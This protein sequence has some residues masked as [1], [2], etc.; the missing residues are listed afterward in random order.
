MLLDFQT[1]LLQYCPDFNIYGKLTGLFFS[2]SELCA[3]LCKL[4][5]FLIYVVVSI[6]HFL[7]SEW[8]LI[9]L[10]GPCFSSSS[11]IRLSLVLTSLILFQEGQ[12]RLES[13]GEEGWMK[14]VQHRY[15]SLLRLCTILIHNDRGQ[16]KNC[17][18]SFNIASVNFIFSFPYSSSHSSALQ[19]FLVRLR[20]F[21]PTK[22]SRLLFIVCMWPT[23]LSFQLFHGI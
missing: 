17:G 4:G 15:L 19:T 7:L 13:L 14:G 18:C 22:F 5:L 20:A 2:L 21:Q 23:W 11:W 10:K 12:V 6:F 1:P 3:P 16:F 8:L 9:E